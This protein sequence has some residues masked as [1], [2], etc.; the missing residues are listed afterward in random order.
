MLLFLFIGLVSV[1][2]LI[3]HSTIINY[4]TSVVKTEN[5]LETLES[6]FAISMRS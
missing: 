4:G 6:V 5:C 3:K 2:D 1:I